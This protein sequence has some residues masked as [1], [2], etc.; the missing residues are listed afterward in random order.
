MQWH[1]LFLSKVVLVTE[2]WP[3]HSDN[4]PNLIQ[5][6]IES[7]VPMSRPLACLVCLREKNDIMQ[8]SHGYF[9]FLKMFHVH[10]KHNTSGCFKLTEHVLLERQT[11]NKNDVEEADL[12]QYCLKCR[13]FTRQGM[14]QVYYWSSCLKAL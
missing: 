11:G 2:F 1:V 10:I 5:K 12:D 7:S 13:F 3:W 14:F 9:L 4:L 6:K 8:G